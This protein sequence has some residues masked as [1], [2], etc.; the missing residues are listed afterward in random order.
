MTCVWR[1]VHQVLRHLATDDRP[2]HL[3][4]VDVVLV[5]PS[6]V[7]SSPTNQRWRVTADRWRGARH[8][9]VP[10]VVRDNKR[11]RT[12][13]GFESSAGAENERRG[14]QGQSTGSP[15]Q[16][17]TVGWNVTEWTQKTEKKTPANRRTQ[18][19]AAEVCSG[20]GIVTDELFRT[21]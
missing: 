19:N 13:H 17:S 15:L 2:S 12:A 18:R 7:L 4:I 9:Q 10:V 11:R 14:R 16:M 5:T 8:R 20:C 3:D 21:R 1:A 6:R